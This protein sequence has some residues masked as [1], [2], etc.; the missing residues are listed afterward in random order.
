MTK[1][2]SEVNYNMLDSKSST[3]KLLF[4]NSNKTNNTNNTNLKAC[5]VTLPKLA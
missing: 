3:N 5:S 4:N 2:D 1:L